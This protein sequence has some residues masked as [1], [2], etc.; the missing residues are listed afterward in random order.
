MIKNIITE[1]LETI[2]TSAIVIL[3]IYSTIAMPE[4]VEGASMEP[5]FYTGERILVERIT[6]YFRDFETGEIVVLHPPQNEN[7][8]FIKRVVGI[9]GDVVK[10]YNCEVYIVR[11][12]KQLRLD[13]PYL[14]EDTCT[15]A[16]SFI[17]EGKSLKLDEN[18]YLVFGDN[19]GASSDSRNFGIVRRENIIGRVIFRFWPLENVGFVK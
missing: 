7:I 18:E 11:G 16:G 5:S 3:V 6:K 15:G 13:E 19:R 2:L 1:T 8:D 12:E 17:K 4:R 9:P 14:H 10:I